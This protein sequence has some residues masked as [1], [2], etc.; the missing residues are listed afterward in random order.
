MSVNSGQ[1]QIHAIGAGVFV[2]VLGTFFHG[3]YE[4]HKGTFLVPW[5]HIA[6]RIPAA[7]LVIL[8]VT[9]IAYRFPIAETV[10]ICLRCG[11]VKSR[12]NV[13][14]C[15]CGGVF[16]DLDEYEWREQ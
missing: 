12:D 11:H 9:L 10:V 14:A 13:K 6:T 4:A 3:Y 1:P 7:L 8:I 2:G 15:S 16:A 5:D